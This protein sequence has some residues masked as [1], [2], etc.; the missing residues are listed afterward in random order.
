MA[1]AVARQPASRQVATHQRLDSNACAL[2]AAPELSNSFPALPLHVQLMLLLRSLQLW[3]R[4][5][6]NGKLRASGSAPA[7]HRRAHLPLHPRL[8][9]SLSV[10]R[11]LFAQPNQVGLARH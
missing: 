7:G 2:H 5:V 6:R 3:R 8:L 1:Q 4:Q 11:K 9:L 10:C